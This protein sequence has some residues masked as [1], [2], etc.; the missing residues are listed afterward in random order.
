LSV[1]CYLKS[2]KTEWWQLTDSEDPNNKGR[3]IKISYSAVSLRVGYNQG[4]TSI[5]GGTTLPLTAGL[6]LQSSSFNLYNKLPSWY[7]FRLL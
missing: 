7:M 6:L 1:S 5:P 2:S 3:V 4:Q